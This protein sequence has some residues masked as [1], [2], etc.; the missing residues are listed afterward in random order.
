MV[1]RAGLGALEKHASYPAE[2]GARLIAGQDLYRL[3]DAGELLGAQARP[4]RPNIGLVLA[5]RLGSLEELLISLQL[6][7]GLVPL[8]ARIRHGLGIV[9]KGLLLLR[10]GG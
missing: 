1:C 5:R 9:A 7:L 10:Q 3:V 4:L 2:S 6:R 8:N